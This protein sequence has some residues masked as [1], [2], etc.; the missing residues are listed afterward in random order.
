MGRGLRAVLLSTFITQNLRRLVSLPRREDLLH[1]KDLTER[2]RIAP[3]INRTYPLAEAPAAHCHP[4]QPSRRA[5]IR[6][7]ITRRS[8]H[9]EAAEDFSDCRTR[10]SYVLLSR[11]DRSV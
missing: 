11:S 4:P 5:R 7:P 9:P 10:H 2:G 6:S 1:L 8:R 3:V